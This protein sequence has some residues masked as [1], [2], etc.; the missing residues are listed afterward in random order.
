MKLGRID[1][2]LPDMPRLGL[3]AFR[4]RI[5]FH[6]VFVALALATLALAVALLN[7]ERQRNAQRYQQTFAKSLAEVVAQL[8]HPSGQLALMNPEPAQVEPGWVAPLVLPFAA[9]DFDD[10]TKAQRAVEMAGCAL[11]Y[12]GDASLCAAVGSNAYAGGFVYLV[13]SMDAP[14]LV[15]RERGATDLADVHRV[16]I[17]FR[18]GGAEQHWLAPVEA[19]DTRRG[20]LPGFTVDGADTA[21]LP[22][23]ARP[24]RDFRGWVW[25]EGPCLTGSEPCVRRTTVSIRLPV[26]AFREALFRPGGPQWPPADLARTGLRLAL[27]G[28]GGIM[29]FDSASQRAQPPLTLPRL[30]GTL[31]PGE[32][33][34]ITRGAN[35][36]ALLQGAEEAGAPPSPWLMALIQ[37]LP[38]PATPRQLTA[39]DSVTTPAGRFDITLTGDLQGLDR[40][41]SASAARLAWPVGAMLGAIAL[42]WLII[43]VGLIRRVAVLTKRAAALSHRLLAPER[44]ELGTLDVADL[45]GRDELGILA[46]SL[47]DLLQHARDSLRREQLRAEREH[48][49]WHAVGHEIMSPLQSLMLLHAADTD[50]SRRYVQRMQ[51]AVK[52]LYGQASPSEALAAATLA[53][54][55]LDLDAFLR[56]VAG[57]AAYAGIADVSYTPAAE[58]VWVQADEYPL[59]DAIT[60]VLTNADRYRLAGTP[61][62]LALAAAN[63]LA[64]ITI[65][66]QGPSIA[67]ELLARIFDYGV[68]DAEPEDGQ[69]RGQGLFVA[70][71]YLAKMGGSIAARNVEDGVIFEIGLRRG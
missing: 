34:R 54:G 42:A 44:F 59:E 26:E 7:E 33:L 51:Q 24:Q 60:H 1:V 46:G 15:G 25:R 45:R 56:Q 69:R 47:S 6:L 35:V 40:S 20:Q 61:I 41:L 39:Q 68:S 14:P 17:S 9:I 16:R 48:D 37:H 43:E 30:A 62:T 27:L 5:V 28:P 21:T 66:N 32:T 8:R 10:A 55:R 31:A 50:P 11:Q 63:E 65:H 4:N 13:A 49:Q 38:A 52:V 12:P 70:K 57:N 36:V 67:D 22:R 18:Q 19:L 23:K 53:P 64:T 2:P 3:A 58:P 29:L 71:T